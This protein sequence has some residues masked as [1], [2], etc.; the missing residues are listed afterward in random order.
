MGW[1]GIDAL[2]AEV[3]GWRSG[4]VRDLPF[5]HHRA[6]GARDGARRSA[7]AAQGRAA[8]YMGYRPLYLAMRALH[9]A[10]S[11]PA[12]VAMIGGYAAAAL[13]RAPRCA[14]AEMVAHLRETQRL[15]M[16]PARMREA[17]GGR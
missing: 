1:D 17:A 15:R 5:R 2:K 9:R 13:H 4:R 14:D 11:E 3:R 16:L 12:A 8:H 7:Y 6:E 10:R